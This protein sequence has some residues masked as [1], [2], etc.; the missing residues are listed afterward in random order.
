MTIEVGRQ[1]EGRGIVVCKYWGGRIEREKDCG[2]TWLDVLNSCW[3]LFLQLR[4]SLGNKCSVA[5]ESVSLIGS[6]QAYTCLSGCCQLPLQNCSVFHEGF[7]SLCLYNRIHRTCCEETWQVPSIC[8]VQ[9]AAYELINIFACGRTFH[10][11]GV[12]Y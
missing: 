9:V 12:S 1:D 2:K 5:S 6:Q 7:C 11:C 10:I 8:F 3:G 4:P